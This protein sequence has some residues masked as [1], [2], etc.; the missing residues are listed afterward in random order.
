MDVNTLYYGDCLEW[1]ERWD[2]NSVDLIYLDPPFNSKANYNMLYSNKGAGDAQFRAFNDT[3]TWDEAAVDRHAMF[4]NAIGRPA[5]NTIIGLYRILGESGMLAYLTYMAE[6]L[7]QMYRILKNTGS[8]YLHCDPTASHYLKIIMDAIFGKMNFRN[9]IV[10]CYAGGGI[11]KKDFP[12]KHDVILRYAKE[13]RQFNVERKPYGPHASSG[14][15]ATDL[16]GTRS[17]EYNVKGT[18]VNDWWHDISPLINWHSEK[19]GYPTQKPLALLE[20][21][22]NASSNEGDVVLD[23]FCGCGTTVDAARRLNRKWV[24]IDIS[25]FAIDLIKE[26]RLKDPNIATKGIPFSFESARKLAK[27]SPFNFETW[28][29]TRLSGFVPNSKQVGDGGVDGRATLA[30][31][32]DDHDSDLG[33]AQVKGSQSFHLGSLRDFLYVSDRDKSAV[34]CFITLNQVSSREAKKECVS[35]GKIHINGYPYPRMQLWSINDYFENRSPN[36]PIMNDPYTGKPLEQSSL[37]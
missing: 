13:C 35:Q 6:R 7:E 8:I 9:E 34:G 10:W 22:I 24:G 11:P 14:R 1:M 21:I 18:P 25:S 32:P 37:F 29:I 16:G 33:L 19:L 20:R 15:R 36:L 12:R 31:K 17:V 30:Y 4:V 26:K 2:D 23:P 3:W 5:H 27:N 28:A